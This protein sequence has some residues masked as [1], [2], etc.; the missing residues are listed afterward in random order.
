MS[1]QHLTAAGFLSRSLEDEQRRFVE[2]AESLADH[3]ARI[4]ARPPASGRSTVS[5]DLTSLIQEATFLLKRAVTIEASLEAVGLM[6]AEA[7]TP[8]TEK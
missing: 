1:E 4:A 8:D 5:G 2:E 3:A 7:G 6:A